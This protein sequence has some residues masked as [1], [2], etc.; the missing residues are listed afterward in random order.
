MSL[1]LTLTKTGKEM[2][3]RDGKLVS[4]ESVSD[5]EKREARGEHVKQ[6]QTIQEK[7]EERHPKYRWSVRAGDGHIKV[8]GY[9]NVV[10][11]RRNGDD[12]TVEE[13]LLAYSAKPNDFNIDSITSNVEMIEEKAK[14][15]ELKAK[16]GL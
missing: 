5:E 11:K 7:L 3:Y 12:I 2:W 1:K 9:H 14:A 16:Y 8:K 4:A 10:K 15:K 13:Q 6:D